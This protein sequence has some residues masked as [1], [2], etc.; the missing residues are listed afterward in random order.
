MRGGTGSTD[1]SQ[2][3]GM[4]LQTNMR[5][6][7]NNA[8][9]PKTIINLDMY[10]DIGDQNLGS[11]EGLKIAWR[12]RIQQSGL[13]ATPLDVGYLAF[14]KQNATDVSDKY[15]FIVGAGIGTETFRVRSDGSATFTGALPPAINNAAG[16]TSA[17]FATSYVNFYGKGSA[18]PKTIRDSLNISSVGD[19]AE[20]RY[21][22]N[23]ATDYPNNDYIVCATSGENDGDN[24]NCT[25]SVRLME[26]GSFDLHVEDVDHGLIDRDFLMAA[27]FITP[28]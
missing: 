21:R 16:N 15:D 24:N 14:Q 10:E 25:V 13:D 5:S 26:V 4:T 1:N 9:T 8:T 17:T 3:A 12:Q 2:P 20:G 18:N 6:T 22:V 11:G 27:V 19:L 23:F 28:T 7:S